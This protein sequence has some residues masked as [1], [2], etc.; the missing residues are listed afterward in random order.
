MKLQMKRC[1]NAT[2][3]LD[4]LTE[5]LVHLSFIVSYDTILMYSEPLLSGI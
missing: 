2:L 5:V 3:V 1:V 4:G